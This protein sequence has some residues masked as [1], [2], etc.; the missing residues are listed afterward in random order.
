M[1]RGPERTLRLCRGVARAD[2]AASAFRV[3][4]LRRSGRPAHRA[5]ADRNRRPQRLRQIDSARSTA[6]IGR[7][8][9]RERVC[10]YVWISVVAASLKKTTAKSKKIEKNK[11]TE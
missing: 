2:Q 9:C 4:E 1:R 5:R 3:Q 11:N 6:Q 8:S 10:Q 7:A